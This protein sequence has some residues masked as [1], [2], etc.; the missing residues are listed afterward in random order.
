MILMV[1]RRI[2]EQLEM[3]P[4]VVGGGDDAA[5]EENIFDGV[6]QIMTEMRFNKRRTSLEMLRS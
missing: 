5:F 2:H 4:Q 3:S 1:A 6:M